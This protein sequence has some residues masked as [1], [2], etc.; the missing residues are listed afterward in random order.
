MESGLLFIYLRPIA[1][2]A[3]ESNFLASIEDDS[4]FTWAS[5]VICLS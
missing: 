2:V 1:E 5:V 4:L 3:F